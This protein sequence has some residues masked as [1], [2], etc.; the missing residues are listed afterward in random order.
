MR[1][2]LIICFA[3]GYDFRTRSIEARRSNRRALASRC[4]PSRVA[5]ADQKTSRKR[6]RAKSRSAASRWLTLSSSSRRWKPGRL[7][8]AERTPTEITTWFGPRVAAEKSKRTNRR[9]HG[10]DHHP[11]GRRPF[12]Q[13][14]QARGAR[15][16]AVQVP[17]GKSTEGDGEE[18]PNTID[19]A[20]EPGPV[21]VPPP[22]KGKAKGK[23]R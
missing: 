8:W 15:E 1:H 22:P 18:G 10:Q 13:A 6:S 11:R 14:A 12:G 5:A 21:E 9:A 19:I 16:S 20:L 17:R 23:T 4:S 2:P 7:R 3:G